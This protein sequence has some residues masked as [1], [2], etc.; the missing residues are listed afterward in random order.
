M[1]HSNTPPA[2]RA[3]PSAP[4]TERDAGLPEDWFEMSQSALWD[5][6]NRPRKTPQA[7]IEAVI[8][9]VR[10]R[11]VAALKE[12]ANIERLL[13][14]DADARANINER[15]ARLIAAKEIAP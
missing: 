7:T 14:C 4:Q 8:Y 5:D 15:V 12:P 13:T 9:S 3:E 1:D 6:P 2:S 11:G 10:E